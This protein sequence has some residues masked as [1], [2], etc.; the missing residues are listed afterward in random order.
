MPPMSAIHV[1]AL[2]RG[3]VEGNPLRHLASLRGFQAHVDAR[4]SARSVREVGELSRR[5][6]GE[7]AARQLQLID[8]ILGVSPPVLIYTA[9]DR[10]HDAAVVLRKVLA[11][12]KFVSE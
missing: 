11:E 4:S 3:V 2:V 8:R 5:A 12:R 1:I 9:G 7:Q 10:Q 6:G